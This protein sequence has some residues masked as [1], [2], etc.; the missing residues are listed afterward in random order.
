VKV[1]EEQ[2]RKAVQQ[3]I[4]RG[5]GFA[6]SRPGAEVLM[7]SFLQ[8]SL[9]EPAQN[10]L[11]N[12]LLRKGIITE[13]ERDEALLHAYSEKAAQLLNQPKIIAP[14]NGAHR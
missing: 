10:A 13:T 11:W 3:V 12:L 9:T 1:T 4:E 6:N 8:A 5:Q 14:T 7:T 2:I